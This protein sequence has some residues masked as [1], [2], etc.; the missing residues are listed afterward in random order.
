MPQEN[1]SLIERNVNEATGFIVP[2]RSGLMTGIAADADVYACANL[3]S[4]RALALTMAR[5]RFVT[6]TPAASAQSLAIRFSKVFG[7]TAIHSGGTPTSIQ[8]HY[9]AQPLRQ[10]A[11]IRIPATEIACRISGTAAMSTSTYTAPDDDEPDFY[12]VSGGATFPA[13]YEDVVPFDGLPPV[14]EPATGI[15]GKLDIAMGASLVGRLYV[16]LLGYWI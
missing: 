2:A 11:G 14:L 13:I 5:V 12:P 15:V 9:L 6:T 4:V 1:Y 8:G 16:A 7:F 10:T 3:N